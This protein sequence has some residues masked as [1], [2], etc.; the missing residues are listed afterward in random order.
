M[1]GFVLLEIRVMAT[2]VIAFWALVPLFCSEYVEVLFQFFYFDKWPPSL[3][4]WC[5][6]SSEYQLDQITSGS[7][8][9]CMPF[10]CC[11]SPDFLLDQI[12]S[13]IL[14]N[15]SSLLLSIQAVTRS[16]APQR[17]LTERSKTFPQQHRDLWFGCFA[18]NHFLLKFRGLQTKYKVHS[19]W[20]FKHKWQK[21]TD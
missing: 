14:N 11:A 1:F 15:S 3:L 20:W 19:R 17:L 9:K 16:S 18:E 2:W 7:G 21:Q 8:H 4:H 10:Y 12:T 5:G 13:H 6:L